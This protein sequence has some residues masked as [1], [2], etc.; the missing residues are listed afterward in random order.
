MRYLTARKRAEG[1]GSAHHGAEH[2][3][4]MQ[5]SALGLALLTPFFVYFIGSALGSTHEE[6]VAMFQRPFPAIVVGLMI[7]AG[8]VHARHGAQ[9][10]IEDYTDGN[11]RK[12]LIML[13]AALTY[14]MI[15]VA[16]FALVKLAL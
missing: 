8:L 11:T 13:V 4:F 12:L 10:L 6:V 1:T 3:W 2:L 16:L 9:V 7:V 5:V 15:A 14:L